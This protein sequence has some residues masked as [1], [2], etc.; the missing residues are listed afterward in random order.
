MK[1]NRRGFL[2]EAV[3]DRALTCYQTWLQGKEGEE[4]DILEGIRRAAATLQHN[5]LLQEYGHLLEDPDSLRPDVLESL[6]NAQHVSPQQEQKNFFQTAQRMPA[7][8][9]SCVCVLFV[10]EDVP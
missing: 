10:E 7:S 8:L 9:N 3:K 4:S 2:R 5:A 6:T 1:L